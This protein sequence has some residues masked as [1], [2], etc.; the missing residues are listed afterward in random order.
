MNNLKLGILCQLDA[1]EESAL[2]FFQTSGEM[3]DL[4]RR[5]RAV[6]SEIKRQAA[7]LRECEN[8]PSSD[9]GVA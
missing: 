5:L 7:W 4:A 3:E 2:H 9:G 6:A 8:S 1:L